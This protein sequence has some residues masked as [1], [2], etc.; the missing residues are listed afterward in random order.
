M[1]LDGASS[2]TVSTGVQEI[3]GRSTQRGAFYQFTQ[4]NLPACK[5]VLTPAAIIATFLLMGL[6]FIPIGLVTLRASNSVVEI[7]DRYDMDCIPEEYRN[8]KVAY[9][10]DDL[11]SKNCSRFLK[12]LKPMKAP[13]YIYYQLDN[14]YQNHR[15]YVK[16]RSD[17]QLLHGLGY[18]DTSSCKPLESSHNLPVVPCGLIAWSLFNDTYKF[19]RGPSE[20]KVNR[21]NIAWKSDRDHKFGKHVYPFNFQNGTLIGGGKLD[22]SIPLG[23]QEDLIVWMRTAALPSFRKLYGRIEEDLDVDDVIVVHLKNNY[24]TYS[25]GGKKKLVLSTSSWL[26]GKNDFLGVANLFVGAFCIFISI[27]FLLL[28]MKNPR[29]DLMGTWPTYLGI[30]KTLPV[31]KGHGMVHWLYFS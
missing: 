29:T 2:P 28:H 4:Q 12:V 8:N 25:F 30:G 31:D 1:D 15:R 26:G 13:I 21:K 23:D 7:V 24:N 19:S 18:N 20:L 16:S 10:K 11:I 22:P 3:P 5:P 17:L 27:I 6:I 9:I 14:Y